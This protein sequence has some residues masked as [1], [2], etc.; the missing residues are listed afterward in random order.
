MNDVDFYLSALP[1]IKKQIETYPLEITEGTHKAIA[2]Y[3]IHAVKERNRSVNELLEKYNLD[4]NKIINLLY[5]KAESLTPTSINPI[6]APLAEEV[7]NLKRI[8]KYE[9]PYNDVFD[10]TKLS[11]ICYDLDRVEQN[12]LQEINQIILYVIQKFKQAGITLTAIDFNYSI[13]LN[14]YMN[15]FFK[16]IEAQDKKEELEIT[17]NRLY[18]KCPMILTH[19]K[20]CIRFLAK[21]YQ[22]KLSNYCIRHKQELIKK[23]GT[24]ENEFHLLYLQKKN[25]LNE[26]ERQDAYTLVESFKKKEDVITDYLETNELR[27]KKLN[28]FVPNNSFS[29]LSELDK[30]KFFQNILELN[31]TLDEWIKIEHYKFLLDDVKNRMDEFKNHKNDTKQKQSEIKKI[32]KKR[33]KIVKQYDWLKKISKSNEKIASKQATKL[34]EIEELI[35]QLNT[36]YHELDDAIITNRAGLRLTKSSTLYDAFEF[37]KSFYGYCKEQIANQNELSENVNQ[38][39]D[40]FEKYVLDCN[41]ILSKNLNLTISYDIK[42]KIHEK[43]TLLNIKIDESSLDDLDSLK[44]DLDFIQKVYDLSKLSITLNDIQFICD[45]NDLK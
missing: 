23:A 13:Y 30:E 27:E 3:K 22:K 36:K 20:L 9:N 32:E 15:V 37:A 18:W 41:H 10:Q 5:K 31:Q 19:L 8:L 29:L 42:E 4:F 12:N 35:Q 39:M 7:R 45:V 26:L 1:A 16:T 2:E 33:A 17:F 14:E 40:D 38:E 21:K 28:S 44:K 25:K 43:C 24:T 34:V 11:K 6:I